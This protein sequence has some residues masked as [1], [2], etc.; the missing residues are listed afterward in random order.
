MFRVLVVEEERYFFIIFV[1]E[2]RFVRCLDI[3]STQGVLS[4][5]GP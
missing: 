4:F 1:G 2:E 5:K 3:T